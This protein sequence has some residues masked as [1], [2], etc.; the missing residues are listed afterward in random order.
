MIKGEIF[1]EMAL[2]FAGTEQTAHF[3][4]VGFKVIGKRMFATYLQKDNTANIF[5]TPEEQAVFCQ[6]HLRNRRYF[7]RWILR[8]FIRFPTNGARKGRQRSNWIV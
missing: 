8:T 3:D 1:T 6:I 7:A 4:R 2:S 5:L